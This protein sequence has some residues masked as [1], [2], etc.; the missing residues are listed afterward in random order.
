MS[1]STSTS[2]SQA[3]P[4]GGIKP[5]WQSSKKLAAC[6]GSSCCK[7]RPVNLR[8]CASDGGFPARCTTINRPL[9]SI[10]TVATAKS[11]ACPDALIASSRLVTGAISTGVQ[12]SPRRARYCSSRSDTF[13]RIVSPASA[14]V[15]HAGSNTGHGDFQGP[16]DHLRHLAFVFT[17]PVTAQQ[18]RLQVVQWICVGVAHFHGVG[19]HRFAFQQILLL[20]ELQQARN[21]S[22]QPF[23]KAGAQCLELV[24]FH[25]GLFV[26]AGN[27]QVGL[28][29]RSE[30][31]TSELQSRPHLV[32]RL[33]LEKKNNK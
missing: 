22:G 3:A 16:L 32:C 18:F 19:E 4:T 33:L 30:E 12:A 14:R 10:S 13:K 1:S 24:V 25:Q 5:G 6:N 15:T 8:S 17:F 26:I 23:P 20:L 7:G 31:H 2:R 27:A 29:Q 21:A 28:G 11:A 9:T